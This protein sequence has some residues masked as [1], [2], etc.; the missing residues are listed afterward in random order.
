MNNYLNHEPRFKEQ[1]SHKLIWGFELLEAHKYSW[2]TSDPKAGVQIWV[3]RQ[4][5]SE[6]KTLARSSLTSSLPLYLYC[7]LRVSAAPPSLHTLIPQWS[8]LFP[9]S[10]SSCL[11][12]FLCCCYCCGCSDEVVFVCQIQAS[13][14]K[15]A[16]PMREIKVQ[17]LVL[18]ISVGES[19][20]RLTR[21]AKV[22][23]LPHNK[24]TQNK[25][26]IKIIY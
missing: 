24:T 7:L 11:L 8:P 13:E 9:P 14:K 22:P 20:D 6:I 21:A 19:G 18:N 26:D 12:E 2:A 16:N 23:P 5:K 1:E 15:L 25:N 10:L 3:L 4:P 17:K